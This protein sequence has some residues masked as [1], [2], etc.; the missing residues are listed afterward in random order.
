M[1]KHI[2]F[3]K[4]DETLNKEEVASKMIHELKALQGN[5]PGLIHIEAGRDF[6]GSSVAFD[7]ALYSELASHEALATY[8]DHPLHVKV[9]EYIGSVT[10]DRC[11]VDYDI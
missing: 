8:Q 7:V 2:V 9:K 10:I 5:I 4:I 3:W 1:V 11:V 6:N